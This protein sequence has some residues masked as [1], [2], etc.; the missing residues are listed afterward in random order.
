MSFQLITGLTCDPLNRA[1][2]STFEFRRTR[3]NSLKAKV[4]TRKIGWEKQKKKHSPWV[5]FAGTL[6]Q[7]TRGSGNEREAERCLS[8]GWEDRQRRT[9]G[10]H[11]VNE[12]W[13]LVAHCVLV[14]QEVTK[15]NM[16]PRQMVCSKTYFC[17]PTQNSPKVWNDERLHTFSKHHIAIVLDAGVLRGLQRP[18]TVGGSRCNGTQ[19]YHL[20]W[21][22]SVFQKRYKA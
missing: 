2:F 3:W 17:Q 12:Q 21:F 5:K 4:R 10:A 11:Q 9:G 1:R 8:K 6:S 14:K 15:T 18:L 19:I 20:N 16:S 7:R 22:S 13:K